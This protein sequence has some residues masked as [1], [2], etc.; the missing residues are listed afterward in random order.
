MHVDLECVIG[1]H[2][3]LS[4]ISPIFCPGQLNEGV[5]VEAYHCCVCLCL[6]RHTASMIFIC[7]YSSDGC[8]GTVVLNLFL[9]FHHV[10]GGQ[11]AMQSMKVFDDQYC[12]LEEQDRALRQEDNRI[13]Q[14]KVRLVP[15]QIFWNG[16][17][18]FPD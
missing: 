5:W 16:T 15:D 9:L 11:G 13:R 12:E 3:F 18:L 10:G 1:H 17:V 6:V 4:I 7:K 8:V 2:Q 14:E